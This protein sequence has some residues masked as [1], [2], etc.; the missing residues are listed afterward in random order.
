ME[1]S[2][3]R[4]P[5]GKLEEQSQKISYIFLKWLLRYLCSKYKSENRIFVFMALIFAN[6]NNIDIYL[7]SL[8]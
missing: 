1:K 3:T 7:I 2:E 6:R 5:Q 4:C 8:C